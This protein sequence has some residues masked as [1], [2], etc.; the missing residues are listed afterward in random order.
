M[1]FWPIVQMVF[2]LLML[3]ACWSLRQL[4]IAEVTKIVNAAVAGLKATDGETDDTVAQHENRIT[5][6]EKDVEGLKE[7]IAA[8]PTKADLARV[9]G[10][11]KGVNG[12]VQGVAAQTA[13]IGAGVDR[14]EGYFLEL[15]VGKLR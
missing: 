2:S 14:L 6:V 1:K 9:E 4:A 12:Q 13:K 5:R 11:V 10:E 8:L 7:D 15:G 3:W